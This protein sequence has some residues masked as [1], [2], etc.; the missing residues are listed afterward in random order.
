MAVGDVAPIRVGLVGYGG[1]GKVHALAYR[2]IPYHYGLPADAVRIVAVATSSAASAERAAREIG[3]PVWSDDYRRIVERDDVDL[4]DC[5]VPNDLHEPVVVAAAAA[6]K[7]IY[8][9]KPLART[10]AEGARMADAVG[11]AGVK[12]QPTF[13]FR[14]F[15]AITRAKQ[16][17]DDGFLGR[18]FSFRG[19]YYRSSYIDAA[20][21]M[22]WR[23]DKEASGGGAMH[24]LGSHV[25]D[26]VGYLLGRCE[27]VNATL[28]TLIDRRPVSAGS[29]ELA[30]VEVDDCCF[31]HLRTAGGVLG[32]VEVSRM[33]TGA[34][35]D[36]QVEV[37]GDRGAIRFRAEEPSWLEVYDATD[38]AE[39]LGGMRGYR[40][41]ETVQ[42]HAGPEDPGLVAGGR[43][44]PHARRVPVPVAARH[45]GRH[46]AATRLPGRAPRAGG[47]GR[48][49]AL[50]QRG[51]M[52]D[53][54]LRRRGVSRARRTGDR[55]ARHARP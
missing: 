34:V 37:F 41:L 8:C 45:L 39:P 49:R 16:L 3:C 21:P 42:H 43:V 23:L 24:D 2:S 26:L 18:V 25:L 47:D 38:P 44:Y 13:N 15:P 28:E 52:G 17:V 11:R 10:V 36:L 14:F 32:L 54:F 31:L 30:P 5:S 7:H 55:R 40:R 50:L 12:A 9:E 53:G 22:S 35:N 27:S 4:V 51:A 48:R 6:G 33:G 19:R 29:D 1:I 46:G 20:K